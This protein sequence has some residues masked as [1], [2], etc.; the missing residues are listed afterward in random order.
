MLFQEYNTTV[1]KCPI[2]KRGDFKSEG[3]LSCHITTVHPGSANGKGSRPSSCTNGKRDDGARPKTYTPRH[4]DHERHNSDRDVV[5][6]VARV[7]RESLQRGSPDEFPFKVNMLFL[8][9]L[10]LKRFA[11]I[12]NSFA[13][14]K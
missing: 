1:I 10:L 2:C 11:M 7:Q 6:G 12:T 5:R 13:L 4:R 8:Y 9:V 14:I 3:G